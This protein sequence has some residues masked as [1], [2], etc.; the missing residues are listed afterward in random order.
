MVQK[1]LGKCGLAPIH[2]GQ[3]ADRFFH[4]PIPPSIVSV[5]PHFTINSMLVKDFA[6][7]FGMYSHQTLLYTPFPVTRFA[8]HR[9]GKKRR[10]ALLSSGFL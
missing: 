9:N 5:A 10:F 7:C 2:V 3:Y 1:L 6:K 8:M 4:N